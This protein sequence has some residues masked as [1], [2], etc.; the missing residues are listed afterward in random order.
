MRSK[1]LITITRLVPEATLFEWDFISEMIPSIAASLSFLMTLFKMKISPIVP[2][3]RVKKHSLVFL[4]ISSTCLD[5]FPIS[6]FAI[7][8]CL[9][10]MCFELLIILMAKSPIRSISLLICMAAIIKRKSEATGCCKAKI[11]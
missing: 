9:S 1:C 2:S 7:K 4:V 3:S 11:L 5:K 10:L 6:N 8:S